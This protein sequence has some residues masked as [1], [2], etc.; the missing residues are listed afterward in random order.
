MLIL[1]ASTRLPKINGVK[2]AVARLSHFIEPNSL[3]VRFDAAEAES[4][5]SDMPLSLQE[6]I[7]GATNRAKHLFRTVENETVISLGVE[8]GLF[9]EMG[10]VFLQSWSCAYDGRELHLG[11]SGAIELPKAL[12]D[13]VLINGT[14]LSIAIDRFAS[15]SDV[16]NKQGTFGILT[17]DF[18]TREDSFELSAL[19]ALMPF[20]HQRWYSSSRNNSLTQR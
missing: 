6:M 15:Q 19:L 8:G 20:F 4:G 3:P 11:C 2:K 9:E 12:S 7:A 16:R 14:E 18:V 1:I 5:V 17:D 10:K 13:D